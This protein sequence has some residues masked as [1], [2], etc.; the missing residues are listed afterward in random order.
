MTPAKAFDPEP[1]LF[2]DSTQTISILKSYLALRDQHASRNDRDLERLWGELTTRMAQR[3]IL[4]AMR[5]TDAEPL[6]M[7]PAYENVRRIM[8]GMS[9]AWMNDDMVSESFIRKYLG[10]SDPA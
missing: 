1:E 10:I 2:T 7:T 9:D 3:D 6:E 4:A 5:T 8:G